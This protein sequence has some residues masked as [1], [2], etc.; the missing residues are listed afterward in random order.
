MSFRRKIMFAPSKLLIVSCLLVVFVQ[1]QDLS[2]TYKQIP[3]PGIE[4][5]AA[6]RAELTAGVTELSQAIDALRTELKDKPKLLALLPDVQI[7]YNAVHYAL[8]YNEIL[9]AREIPYAKVQLK[10]GL[11]RAQELRAGK[12]SWP[13]QTGLVVRGYVS[14]IDGS[15]QPY[16]LVVPPT[17]QPN[18]PH[19]YRLDIWYHG[20]SDTLTEINFLNDRLKNPGQFTPPNTLVLH[21]YGRFCNAN[22]FAGEVDTMEALAHVRQ[23]Y[24]IDENRIAVRGFSM[25]GAAT[26]HIATHY[27]G[28]WA[29][30][31]PGAGFAETAEYLKLG[32]NEPMPPAYQQTLWHWS[33]ATDYA[34]NL[35]NLPVVAYSGELDRQKQAA[36]V[37]ARELKKEGIELTHIIG[38]QTEHKYHPDSIPEINRRIDSIMAK[39]RNPVPR[40]VKFTTYTL[41]YN[42]ML[43]VTLDSLEQHWQ[44]ATIDAE[45]K[46]VSTVHVSTKNIAAFTLEMPAGL[47]P[48]APARKPAV[49][50]D[51]QRLVAPA[52]AS[53]RSWRVHLRK[54]GKAW[55]VVESAEENKIIYSFGNATPTTTTNLQSFAVF[56]PTSPTPPT[57]SGQKPAGETKAVSFGSAVGLASQIQLT[58]K[59][60]LQGPIDDAFLDSFIFVRPTGKPSNEMMGVWVNTEM[61]RA[62]QQWRSQFRGEPVVKDDKD[63]TAA[64]IANNHLILWG[65]EA[66]NAIYG[67]IANDLPI[68]S[69]SFK[70]S[71]WQAQK[72]SP[73]QHI[74]LLIYPNPLNPNRYIVLN[75]GFT[76]RE[77]NVSN[78]RQTPKLPDWAFVDITSPATPRSVGRVVDAG[79]F[80]EHWRLK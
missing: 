43:W 38:P 4:L 20:R 9:H 46:D 77:D 66:S 3:P 15:V 14:K 10:L 45:L 41:R 26:W 56:S 68:R 13:M 27:A 1:A 57:I 60:G 48:F 79:F 76:F 25:G 22:K 6:D 33:N 31:A 72:Y 2:P 7:F 30:A 59:H 18:L 17:Y 73:A 63:I 51:L 34:A 36:D 39:G 47:A 52:P 80:D 19:Q 28:L 37:M 71:E 69:L 70:A 78:A 75:S 23:H 54:A 53:D 35:F 21:P 16:G 61:N 5:P 24:P 50:V 44:R 67:K 55:R 32:T 40:Q 65:D 74:L 62:I 64:D 29:A 12:P 11:E 58:K 49:I 42:K 8:K